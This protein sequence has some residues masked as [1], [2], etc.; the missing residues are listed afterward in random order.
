MVPRRLAQTRTPEKSDSRPM[1]ADPIFYMS[2]YR[3][4]AA[5]ESYRPFVL[6]PVVYEMLVDTRVVHETHWS[7]PPP[8]QPVTRV[9]RWMRG[10]LQ[11]LPPPYEILE[12]D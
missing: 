4:R 10:R 5:D 11:F 6:S 9:R 3:V 8:P 12:V 7:Q 2:I 1:A